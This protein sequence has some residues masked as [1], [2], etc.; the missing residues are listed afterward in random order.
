MS[1][2]A[3]DRRTALHVLDHA[4]RLVQA[5]WAQGA[6]RKRVA[7]VDCFCAGGALEDAC[8]Q[9]VPD[10]WVGCIL[11]KLAFERAIGDTLIPLPLQIPTVPR[12]WAFTVGWNDMKDR[13]QAEVIA[14]FELA[15]EHAWVM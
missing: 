10:A 3:L 5:G 7:G 13:T 8:A 2:S 6:A 14:A 1:A 9:M 4:L 12:S 11:A 15:R